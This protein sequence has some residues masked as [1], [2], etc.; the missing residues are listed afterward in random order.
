MRPAVI[1]TVVL[2]ER[3]PAET[4]REAAQRAREHRSAACDYVWWDEYPTRTRF[5]ADVLTA[6]AFR[7]QIDQAVAFA[8]ESLAAC[9]EIGYLTVVRAPLG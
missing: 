8:K 6:A 4:R 2:N 7:D 9:R 5:V 3:L 1:N